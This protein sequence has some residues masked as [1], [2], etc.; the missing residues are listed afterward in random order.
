MYPTVSEFNIMTYVNS[1]FTFFKSAY[2]VPIAFCW[3]FTWVAL[4]DV[5]VCF[6]LILG[7]EKKSILKR[8][9]NEP[10][11]VGVTVTSFSVSPL[12]NTR[13]AMDHLCQVKLKLNHTKR[14]HRKQDTACICSHS[15]MGCGTKTLCSVLKVILSLEK[16]CTC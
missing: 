4:G 1:L 9:L 3:F 11:Y 14:N 13:V 10:L 16:L 7:R 8:K 2:Y 15:D 5:D 12:Q 6:S